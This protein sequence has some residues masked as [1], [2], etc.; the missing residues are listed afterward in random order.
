MLIFQEGAVVAGPWVEGAASGQ[1]VAIVTL[2][3]LRELWVHLIFSSA[4]CP[5]NKLDTLN[6]ACCHSS[7]TPLT[8]VKTCRAGVST[9]ESPSL[10]TKVQA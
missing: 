10:G 1:T 7:V 2:A 4:L 5:I 3:S 8:S 9:P 6:Q